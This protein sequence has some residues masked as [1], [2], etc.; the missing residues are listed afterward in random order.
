MDVVNSEYLF[1]VTIQAHFRYSSLTCRA[2]DTRSGEG[3]PLGRQPL[4]LNEAYLLVEQA[5]QQEEEE[6]L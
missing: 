5:M 2:R 6:A 3:Q 1:P 4:G